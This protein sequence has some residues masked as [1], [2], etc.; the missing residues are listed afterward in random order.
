MT[1]WTWENQTHRWIA[2]LKIRL[3]SFRKIISQWNGYRYEQL[4]IVFPPH[5][6]CEDP[7]TLWNDVSKWC[8]LLGSCLLGAES[9]KYCDRRNWKSSMNI[10]PS[11][12]L[13]TR[14]NSTARLKMHPFGIF[15]AWQCC[16]LLVPPAGGQNSYKLAY[17]S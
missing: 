14:R 5:L 1:W 7:I 12:R 10:H 17:S 11:E 2:H 16:G 3:K 15:V 6:W 13:V 4:L 8:S 9:M